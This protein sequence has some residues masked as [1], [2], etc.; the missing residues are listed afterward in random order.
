MKMGNYL[1]PQAG[2]NPP[3]MTIIKR[4]KTASIIQTKTLL[5]VREDPL[6]LSQDNRHKR[7]CLRKTWI[8]RHLNYG[9]QCFAVYDEL[10]KILIFSRK[11]N[12]EINNRTLSPL[13]NGKSKAQRN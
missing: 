2:F 3:G 11:Q 9:I 13:L 12:Y 8:Y 5:R 6:K 7:A 1:C 10:F 4:I